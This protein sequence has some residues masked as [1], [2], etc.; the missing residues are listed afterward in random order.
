VILSK[1][2]GVFFS[3]VFGVMTIVPADFW[4]KYLVK[5]I[6]ARQIDTRGVQTAL[7]AFI[8]SAVRS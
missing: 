5:P 7:L 6:P 3:T 2:F 4:S 1:L 8:L